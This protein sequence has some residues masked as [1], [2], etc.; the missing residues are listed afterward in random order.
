MTDGIV[1]IEGTKMTYRGP[2]LVTHWGVSGP[3][4]LKLSAFGAQW[5]KDKN[6]FATVLINWNGGFEEEDFDTHI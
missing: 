3:A 4:V 6:Y 1:K 5:L 2:V